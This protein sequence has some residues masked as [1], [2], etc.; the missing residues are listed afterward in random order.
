[1]TDKKFPGNPTRSYRSRHPLK[2]VGEIESWETF[3]AGFVRELRRRVQE[4]MGEI[5]N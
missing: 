2:V 5:I 3:D 1:M 4:G